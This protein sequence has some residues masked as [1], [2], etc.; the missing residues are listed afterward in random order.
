M[1]ETWF[2]DPAY[3]WFREVFFEMARQ[4]D[5]RTFNCTEGGILFGNGVEMASIEDFVGTL[6]K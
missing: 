2:T 3:Y 4:A 1:G 6:S 5:C